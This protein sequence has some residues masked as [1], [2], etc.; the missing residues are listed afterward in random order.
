MMVFSFC[1]EEEPAAPL[2]FLP[3]H[4]LVNDSFVILPKFLLT[5]TDFSILTCT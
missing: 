4:E 5:T 1:K 2:S 3:Y